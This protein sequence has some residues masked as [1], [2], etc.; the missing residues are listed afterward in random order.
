MYSIR[1]LPEFAAWLGSL[2]DV[3][4]RV[5]LAR[6]L[7]KAQRGLLGDVKPVGNRVSRCASILG[8]AGGCTTRSAAR[9]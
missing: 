9:S 7:D 5:R 4:T 8:L 2:K 1:Q 6:R 3:S